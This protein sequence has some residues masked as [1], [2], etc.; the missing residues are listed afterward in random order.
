VAVLSCNIVINISYY[1][2]KKYRENEKMKS[3]E[4]AKNRENPGMS[5]TSYPGFSLKKH[6]W[7]SLDWVPL[8]YVFQYFP[9]KKST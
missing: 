6:W 4:N 7:S 1:H 5:K 2:I 8:D 3:A 9:L